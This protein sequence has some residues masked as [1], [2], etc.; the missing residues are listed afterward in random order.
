MSVYNATCTNA[1]C[2][3]DLYMQ[4]GVTSVIPKFCPSDGF[5]VIENCPKCNEPIEDGLHPKYCS[6]CG[7]QLRFDPDK[8]RDPNAY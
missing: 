4:V 1:A 8:P 3:F 7:E 5:G 2:T 6:G